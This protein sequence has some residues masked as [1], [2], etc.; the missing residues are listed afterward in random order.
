[1]GRK[2]TDFGI[3]RVDNKTRM[4]LVGMDGGYACTWAPTRASVPVRPC[5]CPRVLVPVR[6]RLKNDNRTTTKTSPIRIYVPFS[7]LNK[8]DSK[9]L[10]QGLVSV[11][12]GLKILVYINIVD[13]HRFNLCL[14]GL[15][16]PKRTWMSLFPEDMSESGFGALAHHVVADKAD[17]C[18]AALHR[19]QRR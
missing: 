5:V 17:P 1:M 8:F 4:S 7:E 10:S 12:H 6:M 14:I 18:G 15:I 16:C 3:R 19:G 2:V 13:K 9:K 11:V